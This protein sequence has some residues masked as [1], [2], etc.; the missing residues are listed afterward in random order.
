M[1]FESGRT[2]LSSPLQ[3]SV[4]ADLAAGLLDTV[5]SSLDDS[6]AEDLITLD[7]A[8]KSSLADHMVIVSGRSHRHVGAIADHLLKD[9]KSAGLKSATVEGQSTCDWVL[10]DAGD[11]IVHIFRPEVR[12]FYN[13][14]KMWAPDT[15]EAPQYIG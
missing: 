14:E 2:E 8:G 10:I 11:V 3:A 13:L 1:T 15:D 5:L 9:L 6:K 12:G 7:I 4:S